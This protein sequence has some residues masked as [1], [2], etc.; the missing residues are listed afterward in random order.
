VLAFTVVRADEDV[1]ST[2][3]EYLKKLA[4]LLGLDAGSVARLE[5]ETVRRIAAAG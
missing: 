5:S 3:R 1:N 2:E 4:G